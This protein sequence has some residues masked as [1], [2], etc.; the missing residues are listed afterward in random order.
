MADKIIQYCYTNADGWQAVAVKG[1]YCGKL[2]GEVTRHAIMPDDDLDEDG[3]PL[4][5]LETIGENDRVLM[6]RTRYGLQ[7]FGAG[8]RRNMF[9]HG[10]E[11]ELDKTTFDPNVFVTVADSNFCQ[12]IPSA[13][14]PRDTFDRLPPFTLESA[15][16]ILGLTRENYAAMIRA[17]YQTSHRSSNRSVLTLQ[18]EN[19]SLKIRALLYCLY[20]GMLP[21]LARQMSVS[22]GIYNYSEV[23]N[24]AISSHADRHHRF[25]DPATGRNNVL[26][27]NVDK[28]VRMLEFVDYAVT[29]CRDAEQ[30][31]AYFAA[32][33]GAAEKIGGETNDEQ[34]RVAHYLCLYP[35]AEKLRQVPDERLSDMLAFVKKTGYQIS[36]AV[37]GML[38]EWEKEAA[39][40][41]LVPATAGDNTQANGVP[42]ASGVPGM[43]GMSEPTA[44]PAAQKVSMSENDI[45]YLLPKIEVTEPK[46]AAGIRNHT[47]LSVFRELT[48]LADQL[49]DPRNK[50]A[51]TVRW[52][53]MIGDEMNKLVMADPKCGKDCVEQ[54]V[55]VLN[56]SGIP[57][58]ECVARLKPVVVSYWASLRLADFTIQ[59]SEEYKFMQISKLRLNDQ[60]LTYVSM[61][62]DLFAALVG[63]MDKQHASPGAY[64]QFLLGLNGAVASALPV[65]ENEKEKVNKACSLFREL[66]GLLHSTA[67]RQLPSLQDTDICADWIGLALFTDSGTLRFCF[68]LAGYLKA[69]DYRTLCRSVYK[70]MPVLMQRREVAAMVSGLLFDMAKF[71]ELNDEKLSP[72]DPDKAVAPIDLWLLCEELAGRAPFSTLDTPR[73]PG[74][75]QP[76][77]LS[78]KKVIYAYEDSELLNE[79]K[80]RA[81]LL[82]AGDEKHASKFVKELAKN[83]QRFDSRNGKR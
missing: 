68:T 4:L 35:T 60:D 77:L 36:D 30:I 56:A 76:A 3:N 62:S 83:V 70:N 33:Q 61:K 75:W 58:A 54:W 23:R 32:L 74:A 66:T 82:R 31:A 12:D 52:L 41:G 48:S 39:A 79:E 7:D 81:L 44:A 57:R 80:Y 20:R 25:F 50:Q 40:R 46:L 1:N 34:L 73:D 42:G 18:C 22:V 19:D 51:K 38:A 69:L 28:N 11:I 21:S 55:A 49:S 13:E 26:S 14:A 29:Y 78:Y 10:F 53:D 67:K 9:S 63:L 65:W 17:L 27:E 59:R 15:M 37:K 2:S 24:V 45:R 16:N 64:E 5:I 72:E 47:V 8:G 43:P 6:I 71:N